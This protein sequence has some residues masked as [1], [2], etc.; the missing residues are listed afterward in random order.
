M[1]ANKKN[2]L[3]LSTIQERENPD[4]AFYWNVIPATNLS[5]LATGW[6]NLL[7]FMTFMRYRKEPHPISFV[8]VD[9]NIG[10]RTD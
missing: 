10:E 2:F 7:L 9:R 6:P 5:I 4:I 3:L 1:T 8:D